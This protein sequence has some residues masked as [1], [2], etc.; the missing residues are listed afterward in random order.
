MYLNLRAPGPCFIQGGSYKNNSNNSDLRTT[1]EWDL[2]TLL[3]RKQSAYMNSLDVDLLC[4]VWLFVHPLGIKV[5]G[6]SH[7]LQEKSC[8]PTDLLYSICNMY[9][10]FMRAT[11]LNSL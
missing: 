4:P 5:L 2:R 1:L 10:L 8:A 9:T 3:A 11:S 6:D 7:T